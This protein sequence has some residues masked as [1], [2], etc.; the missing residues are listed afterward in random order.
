MIPHPV[1]D[2]IPPE[3]RPYM[4]RVLLL[5]IGAAVLGAVLAFVVPAG[6]R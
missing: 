1:L 4:R 3:Y 5:I 6:H 2:R